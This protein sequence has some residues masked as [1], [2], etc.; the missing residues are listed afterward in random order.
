MIKAFVGDIT[1]VHADV[2]VNASNGV[3]IMGRGVAGAIRSV[4]GFEIQDEA[5]KICKGKPKEPGECYITGPGKLS[6]NGVK[7]IYHAVTMKYPGGYTSLDII[8]KVVNNIFI[9]LLLDN[10]ESVA[11]TA[12]G[13]GIGSLDYYSVARIMVRC[14]KEYDNIFNIYFVDQNEYFINKVNEILK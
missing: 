5:K 8:T 14:A 1:A 10:V 3:G 6:E 12:L 11:L 2:I 9:Q 4:G 13:T 7:R